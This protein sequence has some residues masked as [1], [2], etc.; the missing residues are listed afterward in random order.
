MDNYPHVLEARLP[1][2]VLMMIL[3]IILPNNEDILYLASVL[4]RN[5]LKFLIR[6]SDNSSYLKNSISADLEKMVE[7]DIEDKEMWSIKFINLN[8]VRYI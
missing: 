6:Q 5:H 4:R 1:A 8:L 7:D 3:V 2:I